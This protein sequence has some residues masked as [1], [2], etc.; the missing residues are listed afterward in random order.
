LEVLSS[1]AQINPLKTDSF[2]AFF[3]QSLLEGYFLISLD[4]YS[5]FH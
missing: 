1:A 3:F 4:F 5:D 2:Q